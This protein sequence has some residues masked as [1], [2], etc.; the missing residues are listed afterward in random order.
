MSEELLY[1]ATNYIPKL[2]AILKDNIAAFWISKSLD[3]KNGGYII[4]FDKDGKPNGE[5]NKGLVTQA[6]LLWLF[7]RL[8]GAG[9][10][11]QYLKAADLGYKFLKNKMWDSDNGGFYWEVNATGNKKLR[12]RKHLYGQAFALYALSEYYLASEKQEVIVLAHD[13]F[14]LLESWAY[15]D[16]HGGYVEFFN[17][18]WS[19]P[20]ADAD[21][22]MGVE[23]GLKLMNTHLHL[24]EALTIFYKAQPSQI[25]HKRLLELITIQSNSV[26]RKDAGVCTDKYDDDWTPRLDVQYARVSYGHDLEN[27][28]LLRR[29]CSAGGVSDYPLL[30]LYQTLFA[31][32]LK[33]GYDKSEGGFFNSG[34][35]GQ[36]ADDRNKT[37]WVQAEAIVSAL[38]IY[39]L[40]KQPIYLSVFEET[41]SFI[42]N[43]MVDRANGEWHN[44]LTPRNA[45][46]GNKADEWKAGYH[47]GRSMIECIEILKQARA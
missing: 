44:T 35:I 34:R 11:D 43:F 6:R 30:N 8:A 25:S 47:S 20:P 24:M 14:N 42:E 19:R 29:A 28:W 17:E 2:E 37:W 33:Y 45:I 39:C 21:N 5:T 9:F 15:D 46:V 4:N 27:I 7:A 22:Y 36:P 41:F 1:V 12:P 38:D 40:T 10:G 13:L 3:K 18:D 32:S 16:T 26:V 23:T 31:S